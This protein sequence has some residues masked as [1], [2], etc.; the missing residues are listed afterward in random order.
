MQAALLHLSQVCEGIRQ[1]VITEEKIEVGMVF[2]VKNGNVPKTTSGKIQRWLAKDKLLGGRMNVVLQMKFQ[3][4]DQHSRALKTMFHE[5][6]GKTGGKGYENRR[7]V[8]DEETDR[9][10]FSQSNSPI[11]P[12]FQSSL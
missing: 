7:K 6:E 3:D 5:N 10:F 1:A 12:S 11:Y 4:K 9:V 2:L 8:L